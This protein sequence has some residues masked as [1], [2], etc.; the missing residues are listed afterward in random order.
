VKGLR[1]L[2]YYST[3]NFTCATIWTTT[4]MFWTNFNYFVFGNNS[5]F[6]TRLATR[7]YV[8][9]IHVALRFYDYPLS[10]W[11]IWR[12][13]QLICLFFIICWSWWTIG[14]TD[15]IATVVRS[16]GASRAICTNIIKCECLH[17]S[18]WVSGWICLFVTD[19]RPL[20]GSVDC[21]YIVCVVVLVCLRV[22]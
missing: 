10:C 6:N 11:W 20:N 3:E 9:L 12:F 13:L 16:G 7:I 2:S 5:N 21:R 14:C 1:V 18:L 4:S 17:V 22:S 8:C 19:N 15:G